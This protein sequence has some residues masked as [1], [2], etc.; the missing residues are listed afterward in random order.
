MASADLTYGR[1]K[2]FC[3]I[4]PAEVGIE[5][6]VPSL[7]SRMTPSLV[8]R[9]LAN[10]GGFFHGSRYTTFWR[11]G[12]QKFSENRRRFLSQPGLPFAASSRRNASSVSSPN[13]AA[14]SG[15]G[16]LLHGHDGL[17]FLGQ[18]LRD[19]KEASCQA[20]VAR[21]VSY[22]QESGS[23]GPTAD[24]GDYCRARNKLSEAALHE[25]S[26]EVAAET[27]AKPPADWLWKGK[28]AKLIDGFTFT[29]PDTPANRAEFPQQVRRRQGSVCRSPA[30]WRS[31]RW[32]PP[33]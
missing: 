1:M 22:C 6:F 28:H 10:Q 8:E 32:R 7:V 16:D 9:P 27:E 26:C 3:K 29:M 25:L 2:C 33:A 23:C 19:G 24:T 30:W 4:H 31:S 12:Q 11:A 20:A 18:V 15:A 13:T 17:V 21:V 5:C 14:C